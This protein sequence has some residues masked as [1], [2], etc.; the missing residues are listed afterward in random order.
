L[1]STPAARKRKTTDTT[2]DNNAPNGIQTPTLPP[3]STSQEA[4][5][6]TSLNGPQQGRKTQQCLMLIV[7]ISPNYEQ[8]SNENWLPERSRN[9]QPC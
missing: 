3:K 7:T 6:N 5:R 1:S 4:R 2:L 8:Q 9:P